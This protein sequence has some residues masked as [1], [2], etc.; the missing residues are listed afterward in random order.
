MI[1]RFFKNLIGEILKNSKKISVVTLLAF[2]ISGMNNYAYANANIVKDINNPVMISSEHG[3]VIDRFEGRSKEK[4][5]L[6]QDLH[7]DEEVQKNISKI[8]EEIKKEYGK[9]FKEIGIEGTP[10]SEIKTDKIKEIKDK[11]IRTGIIN[12]LKRQEIGRA[13]CR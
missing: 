13:A 11:K 2:M 5:I 6:I 8:L 10:V 12:G 9:N 3:K 7:C 4:I 1:K